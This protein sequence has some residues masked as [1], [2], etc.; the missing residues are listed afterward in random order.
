MTDNQKK[1]GVV[2]CCGGC[3]L[4]VFLFVL[5]M[6]VLQFFAGRVRQSELVLPSYLPQGANIDAV[7]RKIK[8]AHEIWS[9]YEQFQHEI[10]P[11]ARAE[12]QQK[13]AEEAEQQRQ[14]AIARAEVERQERERQEAEAKAAA[15]KIA[16]LKQNAARFD[17]EFL[18]EKGWDSGNSLSAAVN[19]AIR[20]A[21]HFG[22]KA[23]QTEY[24]EAVRSM[25]N[26]PEDRVSLREVV[27]EVEAKIMAEREKT[28]QQ[29]FYMICPSQCLNLEVDES[30][31]RASFTMRII[32]HWRFAMGTFATFANTDRAVISLPQSDVTI[33]D[34]RYNGQWFE[35]KISGS[36]DSVR[37]LWE[38]KNNDEVRIFFDNFGTRIPVSARSERPSLNVLAIDIIRK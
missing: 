7:Q 1:P 31:N 34:R 13:E 9:D 32:T 28:S 19:N 11:A 8:P 2:S 33:E 20:D 18:W 37:E 16:L 3:A 4:A 21:V 12:R 35:L 29:S 15:E 14:A 38:G 30:T 5:C 10:S 24:E 22:T 17:M 36:A 27:R 25:N 23:L 6:F 26:S